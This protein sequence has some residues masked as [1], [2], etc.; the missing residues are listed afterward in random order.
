LV[1]N[2]DGDDDADGDDRALTA[3]SAPPKRDA[4]CLGALALDADHVYV[5]DG[6]LGFVLRLTP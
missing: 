4:R 1:A 2:V 6:C 5:A 3:A